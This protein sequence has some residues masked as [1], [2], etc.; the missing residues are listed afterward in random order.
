M[1]RKEFMSGLRQELAGLPQKEIDETLRYY[2]EM[3]LDRMEEGMT[4]EQAVAGMEPMHVIA[5]RV[6]AEVRE[7]TPPRPKATSFT[8]TLVVLGFPVWFPLLA[9]VIG[10]MVVALILGWVLVLVMWALCLGLFS[11][12][13]AALIGQISGA[14]QSGLPAVGQIGLGMAAMGLSVFLFYGAKAA[15]PLASRAAAGV[16]SR[17]RRVLRG[18]NSG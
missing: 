10:L 15:V 14:Y 6:K 16:V 18:R 1:T 3:L 17:I 8:K 2:S 11:G 13:M 4:E 5:A 9:L 7:S 12:G